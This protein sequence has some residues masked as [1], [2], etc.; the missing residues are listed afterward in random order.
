MTVS[1]TH[2]SSDLDS[3]DK[4]R[5]LRLW[6][7]RYPTKAWLTQMEWGWP[8]TGGLSCFTLH[9][10]KNETKLC[11]LVREKQF[12]LG[13]TLTL[14]SISSANASHPTPFIFDP[15][16]EYNSR[17]WRKQFQGNFRPCLGPRGRCLNR[18]SAE[19]MMQVYKGNQAGFPVPV[20]G[21]HEAIGLDGNVC[22]DRYS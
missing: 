9:S 1:V 13:G 18:K 6:P 22:A 5:M 3:I 7:K 19:D 14:T 8:M 21:S 15:Y 11:D 10:V 20:F 12:Y 16:P 17:R 4:A 2:K